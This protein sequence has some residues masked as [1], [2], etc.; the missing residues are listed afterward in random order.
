MELRNTY[1]SPSNPSVTLRWN[2]DY[3]ADG[4]IN[5]AYDVADDRLD[6]KQDYDHVGRLKEAYSGREARG[7][8]PTNPADSPFRQSFGYDAFSNMSSRTGRFWRQTQ[9]PESATYTNDRRGGWTYD[10]EGNVL[11]DLSHEN[12]FDAAGRQ[13]FTQGPWNG[14]GRSYDIEQQYDGDGRAARR[15]ENNRNEDYVGEPPELNCTTTSGTTYYVY[16]SAL[17]GVKLIELN[18]SGVKAKGYVYGN[19]QRLAVQTVWPGGHDVSYHHAN[20]LTGS[21]AETSSDRS[22]NRREMGPLGEELGT[23]DPYI[24]LESPSY[25]DVHS[26]PQ[27]IEGGD[28][29]DMGSGCELDGMAISCSELQ[30]RMQAGFVAEEYWVRDRKPINPQPHL[31]PKSPRPSVPPPPPQPTWK[32]R[33]FA[34]TY[35]GVGLFGR[36]VPEIVG[37]FDEEY[38]DL[39]FAET[40]S[41]F[42]FPQ[43]PTPTPQTT[44]PYVDQ[45]VLNKCLQDLFGVELRSF[46]DSRRVRNGSFTGFGPDRLSG[47]GNN[48][49]IDVVNE[50]NAYTSG[51]LKQF[52]NANLPA[53]QPPLG[54]NDF[55]TGLTWSGSGHTPY[56]NFTASNLRNSLEILKTQVHEL[57]HS[58]QQIVGTNY[59]GDLAGQKLEDCVNSNGGFR[60]R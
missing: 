12:T 44:R 59:S 22:A 23:Y 34:I 45:S 17:G 55:V 21:W 26:G 14:C 46:T 38:F 54:P 16:A 10:A 30:R 52:I 27:F 56:R 2:Y 13:T 31:K 58:L 36:H 33:I 20:P 42:S 25:E 11:A 40:V 29:F 15:V 50:V 51:R 35:F 53:G 4:R 24:I 1:V 39:V 32:K 7:L 60:R 47:G 37:Q 18:G 41:S 3:Y 57:G 8:T 28:P 43:K 19:G 5:H 49:Q 48:T 6:R 9:L